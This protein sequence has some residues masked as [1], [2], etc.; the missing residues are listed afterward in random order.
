[1][2]RSRFFDWVAG[3]KAERQREN[4]AELGTLAAFQPW[5]KRL[6]DP[7]DNFLQD[8]VYAWAGTMDLGTEGAEVVDNSRSMQSEFL[9]RFASRIADFTLQLRLRGYLNVDLERLFFPGNACRN[10][11][12]SE[13]HKV[14]IILRDLKAHFQRY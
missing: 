14:V 4:Q 9:R 10:I 13:M 5:A 2:S 6:A 3:R 12:N 11:D 1:M 7:I 8:R